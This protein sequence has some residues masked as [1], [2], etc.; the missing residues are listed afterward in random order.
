[1]L[2]SRLHTHLICNDF[3]RFYVL[4]NVFI[5]HLGVTF[6]EF[7][8]HLN[9][10]LIRHT[11]TVKVFWQTDVFRMRLVN[12]LKASVYVFIGYVCIQL[13]E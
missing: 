6:I 11:F 10:V 9:V 7:L 5:S 2:V 4:A 1:M 3:L 13:I 8:T 12:E